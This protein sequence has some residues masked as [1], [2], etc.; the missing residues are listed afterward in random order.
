MA[1]FIERHGFIYQKSKPSH[2]IDVLRRWGQELPYNTRL[3]EQNI[4]G[5]EYNLGPIGPEEEEG[6]GDAGDLWNVQVR[7]EG[8]VCGLTM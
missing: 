7:M 5:P 4:R 1:N 8:C 3:L 2:L 6:A